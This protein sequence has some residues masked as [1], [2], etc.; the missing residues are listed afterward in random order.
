MPIEGEALGGTRVR[1]I[2]S[3]ELAEDGVTL[4]VL[5]ELCDGR[6]AAFTFCPEEAVRVHVVGMADDYR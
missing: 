4:M 5:A 3:F 1:R 6:L 2:D